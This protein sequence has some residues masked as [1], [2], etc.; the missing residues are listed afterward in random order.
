MSPDDAVAALARG[1]AVVPLSPKLPPMT[2]SIRSQ[3]LSPC[4][5]TLLLI[6]GAA[7]AFM[8]APGCG[9]T[10]PTDGGNLENAGEGDGSADRAR[11]DEAYKLAQDENTPSAYASFL[12]AYPDAPQAAD[13]QQRYDYLV[14][15]EK[16]WPRVERRNTRDA[17]EWYASQFPDAPN[18]DLARERLR[19]LLKDEF[20]QRTKQIDT[21]DAYLAFAAAHEQSPHLTEARARV[22]ELREVQEQANAL[23]EEG[24]AAMVADPPRRLDAKIAFDTLLKLQPAP[25]RQTRLEARSQVDEILAIWDDTHRRTTAMLTA[26]M[27]ADP[28]RTRG[29]R[30]G[31]MAPWQEYLDKYPFAPEKPL[32]EQYISE[33]MEYP[34]QFGREL[35]ECPDLTE[36]PMPREAFPERIRVIIDRPTADLEADRDVTIET[37]DFPLLDWSWIPAARRESARLFIEQLVDYVLRYRQSLRTIAQKVEAA[38]GSSEMP[39]MQRWLSEP[40]FDDDAP[41]LSLARQTMDTNEDLAADERMPTLLALVPFQKGSIYFWAA[42]VEGCFLDR[43]PAAHRKQLVELAI[44]NVRKSTATERDAAL[45]L[46]GRFLEAIHE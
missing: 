39:A 26:R 17:Y 30:D 2:R 31:A 22:T 12:E 25:S 35:P 20:W 44:T 28:A 23:L 43:S 37:G 9:G 41:L 15:A 42:N 33:L 3:P 36:L 13:A 14:A 38:L 21:I 45:A 34:P 29:D 6:L 11:I 46:M 32:L 40:R 19:E 1:V 5:A 18:A 10:S 16:E 7:A 4:V 24:R 27:L 8:T